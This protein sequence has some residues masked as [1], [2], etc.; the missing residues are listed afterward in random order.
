MHRIILDEMPE[1]N[2]KITE[3]PK[4]YQQ[5]ELYRNITEIQVEGQTKYEADYLK[6]IYPSIKKMTAKDFETQEQIDFIFGEVEKRE[7]LEQKNNL[8]AQ[9]NII[10]NKTIRPM[11]AI[12]SGQGTAQDANKLRELEQQ[13]EAIRAKIQQLGA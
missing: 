7:K 13:A 5:V 1:Q 9:L 6:L 4:G 3:L 11:R 12:N 2:F 8:I 10:D